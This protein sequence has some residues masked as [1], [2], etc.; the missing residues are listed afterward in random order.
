MDIGELRERYPRLTLGQP[1]DCAQLLPFGTVEQVQ[2]ATTR[3]ISDA[4]EAGI[5][6]GSTSEIH[7]EVKVKNALS[8]YETARNYPLE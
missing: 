6:V 1:I 3:A 8:M 2:R 5:I 4:G 7:S